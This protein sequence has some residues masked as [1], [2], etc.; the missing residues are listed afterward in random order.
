MRADTGA[1][2]LD[3]LTMALMSVV[4]TSV[5][6]SE[7]LLMHQQ[8]LLSMIEKVENKFNDVHY[9]FCSLVTVAFSFFSD[10]YF[11]YIFY[12]SSWFR[13]RLP[14]S[15][16]VSLAVRCDASLSADAKAAGSKNHES[17]K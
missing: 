6:V 4:L 1:N 8:E 15:S 12:I 5:V 11:R 2:C 17:Q 16:E 14:P 9:V 3:A 13:Q 7:A 10:K